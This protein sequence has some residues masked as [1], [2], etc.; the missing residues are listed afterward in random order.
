MPKSA[1]RGR[2]LLVKNPQ[3]NGLPV[4]AIPCSREQLVHAYLSRCLSSL[5]EQAFE[6]HL[7]DCRACLHAIEVQRLLV[8]GISE[9]RRRRSHARS[10]AKLSL[11]RSRRA[12]RPRAKA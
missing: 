1:R 11:A 10:S 2:T 9:F 6:L 5:S 7:M 12:R 8:L 4:V 3:S